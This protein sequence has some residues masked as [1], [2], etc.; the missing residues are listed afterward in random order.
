MD[1]PDMEEYEVEETA[2]ER[3]V[4]QIAKEKWDRYKQ[5]FIP[6]EN[7]FIADIS[8]DTT[9]ME[10]RV[11]GKVNADVYQKIIPKMMQ[12]DPSIGKASS[13]KET[14]D[15]GGKAATAAALAPMGVGENQAKLLQAAVDVGQSQS[16]DVT[17]NYSNLAKQQLE[18]QLGDTYL[19]YKEDQGNQQGFGQ[20]LGM[21]AGGGMGLM[22][23]LSGGSGGSSCSGGTCP[24]NQNIWKGF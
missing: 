9:G 24:T 16:H 21:L 13:I 11:A 20:L 22:Q 14:T 4:A 8:K 19:K 7:A 10:D 15:V 6:F 18:E 5:Q 2:Y 3:T 12:G 23:G 17:V 1:K